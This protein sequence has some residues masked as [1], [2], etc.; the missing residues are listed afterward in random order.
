MENITKVISVFAEIGVPKETT[1]EI[2]NDLLDN[3]AT[4]ADKPEKILDMVQSKL[5]I[6]EYISFTQYKVF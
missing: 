6:D 2:M 1:I 4:Y 3:A 5:S